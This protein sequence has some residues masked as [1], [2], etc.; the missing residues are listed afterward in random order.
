MCRG[1]QVVHTHTSLST[2]ER[3][4]W[5]AIMRVIAGISFSRGIGNIK[6]MGSI[7][8]RWRWSYYF[9]ICIIAGLSGLLKGVAVMV[10]VQGATWA[11]SRRWWWHIESLRPGALTCQGSAQTVFFTVEFQFFCC[12]VWRRLHRWRLPRVV[13]VSAQIF[14]RFGR[15]NR[16]IKWNRLLARSLADI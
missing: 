14:H 13:L 8:L 15:G 10:V 5:R 7:A 9:F 3:V 2:S 16:N 1:V 11:S 12:S 4:T 6:C